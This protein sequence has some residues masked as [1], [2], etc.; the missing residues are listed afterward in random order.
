M[1]KFQVVFL[2]KYLVNTFV[3]YPFLSL[4]SL[5]FILKR[6]QSDEIKQQCATTK[7]A[8]IFHWS[9]E[10]GFF[11]RLRDWSSFYLYISLLILCYVLNCKMVINL[12]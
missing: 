7:A 4:R 8:E 10:V 12:V 3:I 5:Y 9:E 1:T 6:T 11:H 2:I